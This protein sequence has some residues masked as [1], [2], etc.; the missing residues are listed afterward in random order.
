MKAL[1]LCMETDFYRGMQMIDRTDFM[2]SLSQP[3]IFWGGKNRNEVQELLGDKAA[4]MVGYDQRNPHHCYDL[5]MHSLHTVEFLPPESTVLLRTAAF[6]HDAGK[7]CTAI[8]KQGRLVF[9]G[10]AKKS[11]EIA[12]DI[13]RALGYPDEEIAEIC[14]YIKHHDDFISWVLPEEKSAPEN[15]YQ[16]EISKNNIEKHIRKVNK[17]MEGSG[18]DITR[19]Y[20]K[21]LIQLCLADASAQADVVIQN[22][23][24]IDTKEHKIKK[25]SELRDLI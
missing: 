20:W 15:K 16:V 13:L 25:L 2:M 3:I 7:P 17:K 9:Y 4:R 5:F 12:A 10:H 22:G 19:D 21:Q 11:A 1:R 18:M 23:R 6:F 24:I 8:E 14:F